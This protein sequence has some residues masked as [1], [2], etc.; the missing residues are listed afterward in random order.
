MST[1]E[2]LTE[3]AAKRVRKAA[4]IRKGAKDEDNLSALA[5]ALG[6]EINY[7][8]ALAE[9]VRHAIELDRTQHNADAATLADAAASWAE[10]L[11]NG[12]DT[13]REDDEDRITDA[14]EIDQIQMALG[15]FREEK[16]RSA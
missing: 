14:A 12:I 4:G 6:D 15:R 7:E 16:E 9:L 1:I 11:T 3:K 10:H 2:E 13:M 5:W 8:F